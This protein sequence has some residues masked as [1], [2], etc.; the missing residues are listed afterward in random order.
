[1]TA[2]R[3]WFLHGDKAGDN[4]QVE[5]IIDSLGWPVTRKFL[6][7]REE[8]VWGKPRF[9]ATLDHLDLARSD[10]LEPPWP[11]LIVTI[12]RRPSMAALWVRKKAAGATRIILVGKPTGQMRA[13]ELVVASAENQLPPLANL[14]SITLPLMRVD[15]Q[16]VSDAAARWRSRLDALPRPLI[17]FLIGGET[18][19][20]RMD[21]AV[22]DSLLREARRVIHMGG[23]PYLTTSRRT[24]PQVVTQLKDQLPEGAQLF[25]WDAVN[26]ENP[27]KAL[28]GLADGFIVTG[29]SISMMV[30]VAR[31]EKPLQIFALP[32]DRFGAVDQYRRSL[33]HWLFDPRRE[34]T[35]DRIRQNFARA[36]Y[37]VDVF[38]LLCSTR[39]FSAFHHLL[40]A[41][42]LADWCGA[43]FHP[44][45]RPLPDDV[46]DVVR[47]I[48]D[49]GLKPEATR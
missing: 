27:Y 7:M 1:M 46:G 35:A 18:N 19:P 12:G 40:V 6:A 2:P 44:P 36:L 10:P 33:A 8:Y 16:A 9:R 3:L 45:S 22:A 5:T 49:I 30:E 24:P 13:F 23:T 26:P 34:S 21:T 28:L 14:L 4:G 47:R 37:F 31:M 29:D 15:H 38:G 41:N 43:A 48:R 25:A 39:D 42:G 17:G 11:D 20:Y 32:F